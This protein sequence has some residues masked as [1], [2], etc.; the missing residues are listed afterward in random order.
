MAS[1]QHVGEA[2][3]AAVAARLLAL[4]WD[5]ARPLP[6][7]GIDLIV[8]APDYRGAVPVQ[9]KTARSPSFGFRKSWYQPPDTVLVI[10]W[11]LPSAPRFMLFDG[12]AGV[13]KFLGESARTISWAQ[14]GVWTI[15]SLSDAQSARVALVED[16]WGIFER[17]LRPQIP[18]ATQR[19]P[20]TLPSGL[21]LTQHA[22]ERIDAGEVRADWIALAL[23]EPDR[24]EQDPARA[25]LT[26]SYRR[27]A[28]FGGRV[29]RVVHRQDDDHIL[30]VTAFFDRGAMP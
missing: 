4:G 2:G 6:D 30:V 26:R 14:R 28:A 23:A 9:V 19:A 15:S 22:R 29:L 11:L 1:S 13:E 17:R 20:A 3:E 24:R 8:L 25:E 27:I 21:R 16:Q 7:R 5:V 10:V 18:D 12:I